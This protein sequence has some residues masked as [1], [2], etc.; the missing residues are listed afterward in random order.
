MI[1]LRACFALLF[2]LLVRLLLLILLIL[3]WPGRPVAAD[4]PAALLIGGLLLI[5]R[6]LLGLARL[7]VLLCRTPL[8]SGC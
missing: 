1:L 8:A 6:L 2:L 3:L 4:R 5:C 7:P